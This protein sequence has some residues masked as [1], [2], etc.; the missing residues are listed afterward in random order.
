MGYFLTS[1]LLVCTMIF[2]SGCG[3]TSASLLPPELDSI[4]VKNVKNAI[5]PTQEISDKRMSVT[6]RPGMDVQITRAVIDGFIYDRRL[7]IKSESKARM[8]LE[9]SLTDFRLYPLSYNRG[10][11]VEEFRVEIVINMKLI[12]KADDKVLWEEN[13]FMGQSDYKLSGPNAMTEA[14]AIQ[15]AVDDLAQRVVER[16]VENW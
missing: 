4:H 5:N 7:D 6:Y 2:S 8:V 12:D 14:Q 16:T 1:V 11:S 15:K 3:Y 10:G 9:S 13:G